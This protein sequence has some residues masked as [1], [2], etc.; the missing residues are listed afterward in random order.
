MKYLI[1][2][3]F[4]GWSFGQDLGVIEG[5]IKDTKTGEGLPGVNIL[6]KG[7]YYGAAADANGRY[8]IPK[9]KPG[10]Y[11]IEASIIGYKVFL[12]TGIVIKSGEVINLDFIMERD[13]IGIW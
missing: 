2:L 8:R 5:I 13:G 3:F 9:V 12:K 7:T 1:I 6:I 4:I 10:N 11:D